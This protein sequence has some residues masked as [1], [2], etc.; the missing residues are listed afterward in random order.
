MKFNEGER[1]AENKQ[2]S[3][4]TMAS[5]INKK[6]AKQMTENAKRVILSDFDKTIEIEMRD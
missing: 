4:K 5:N 2:R 1:S 6:Q 3:G